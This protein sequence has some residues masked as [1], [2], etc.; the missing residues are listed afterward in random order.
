[1]EQ[2]RDGVDQASAAENQEFS[3]RDVL[4]TAGVGAA[5]AGALVSPAAAQQPNTGAGARPLAAP[6][7]GLLV[8]AKNDL[9]FIPDDKLESFKVFLRTDSGTN[10]KKA[11]V[12]KRLRRV[13]HGVG[14]RKAMYGKL[15]VGANP[16]YDNQ[17]RPAD[18]GETYASESAEPDAILD[19]EDELG[20]F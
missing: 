15:G 6:S 4:T 20:D 3:R 5:V 16:D 9:Y 12:L 10:E 2:S 17:W 11:K 1:M 18:R 7:V 8:W 13:A 19:A 14:I